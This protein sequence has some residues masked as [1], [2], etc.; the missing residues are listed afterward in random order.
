M[1]GTMAGTRAHFSNPK[2]EASSQFA[3]SKLGEIEQYVA[4]KDTAWHAGSVRQPKTQLP[5][6]DSVSPNR[7]SIGIEFE[8]F[9]GD[10]M[11]EAQYQAGLWLIKELLKQLAPSNLSIKQKVIGHFQVNS[12][13]KASCPGP[14]FPWARFYADL[15]PPKGPGVIV[16]E[17]GHFFPGIL[18]DGRMYTPVRAP[19]EDL[20]L[21]VDYDGATQIATIRR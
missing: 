3:V 17:T 13:D 19:F 14:S 1:A 9:P 20:G 4:I 2:N 11:P 10:P 12:I 7:Y 21:K 18:V 15:E 5:Y 16:K 6:P 8:G